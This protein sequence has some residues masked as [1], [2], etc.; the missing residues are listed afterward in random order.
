MSEVRPPESY[1]L[2]GQGKGG[3]AGFAKGS[4]RVRLAE[5]DSN[6]TTLTYTVDVGVGG[7][8]AQLGSRLIGGAIDQYSKAFFGSLAD[9]VSAQPDSAERVSQEQKSPAA[10]RPGTAR[11]LQRQTVLFVVGCAIVVTALAVLLGIR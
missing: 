2:T 6:T 8:L 7:K 4:A 11:R 10:G 9:A 1:V 5:V 3:A